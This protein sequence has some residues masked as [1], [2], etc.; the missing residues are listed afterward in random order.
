MTVIAIV[1]VGILITAI[2]VIALMVVYG[3][4]ASPLPFAPIGSAMAEVS[5]R[6]LP[7]MRRF[8]AR[9]GQELTYRAYEADGTRAAILIHGQAMDGVTLHRAAAALAKAG[10]SAFVPTIRGHGQDGRPGD[11]DYAGQLDDDLAD[12]LTHLRETR[13]ETDFSLAGHSAGGG[14]VIRIAQS[15]LSGLFERFVLLAPMLDSASPIFRPESGKWARPH[16][17][18]IVGL[19]L[20]DAFGIHRFE[21]LP[22]LAFGVPAKSSTHFVPSYSY[23]L[24]KNFSAPD[25]YARKLGSILQPIA[26]IAGEKDEIL[27]SDSYGSLLLPYRSDISIHI[28]PNAGH[29][30]VVLTPEALAALTETLGEGNLPATGPVE[31]ET[32]QA[33]ETEPAGS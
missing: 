16:V 19:M 9:D 27:A 11:I 32:L 24:Q 10:M 28:I 21:G 13:P 31:P 33:E 25:D 14:F 3:T 6:D 26:L 23:R 7:P 18:R 29:M 20:L 12:F 15:A 22:I 5:T 17:R 1:L 8:T 30:G 2:A 4:T